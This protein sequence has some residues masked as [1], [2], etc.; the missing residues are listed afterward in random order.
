MM[1][2]GLTVV[3]I[4]V[5]ALTLARGQTPPPGYQGSCTDAGCHAEYAKRPV[6]HSPVET[7][8]CDA[9]HEVADE[10]AHKFEFTAEESELCVECHE[11]D[12]VK[13]VH[14]PV[15]DGTCT[16]CHDPH[17]SQN[18]KLLTADSEAALCFECHDDFSDEHEFLHGPVA[19][20][21]CTAC[22]L[23]HGSDHG[24]IL[25]AEGSGLCLRCHSDMGSRI[26]KDAGVHEPVKGGCVDC[27]DPH[28]ADHR[29]FV[30]SAQ[31]DLCLDCH[32]EISDLVDDAEVGHDA[33]T[34]DRACLN[35]HDPHE[36]AHG[37][38]LLNKP[39][40]LCLKCHNQEL[41]SGD[42][43]LANIAKHLKEKPHH[44]GPIQDEDCT[45]CHT[46]HGGEFFRLL[47]G[48]FPGSFY[49][50]YSEDGYALCFECHDVELA[51]EEATDEATGFRN[52]EKNLHFVHVNREV[53]GRTCR[54]CH[55]FH[56]SD[57]DKHIA[58]TVPFGEWAIPINYRATEAG[59]S[60]QP[61][62][63]KRYTYDR[64]TAV[65]N[66]PAP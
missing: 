65:V 21:T 41:P 43:K 12:D 27:H 46:P 23:P 40:A 52:G 2:R 57:N 35:C 4:A 7:G 20:E 55:D 1:L 64:E 25:V 3:V 13:T 47:T 19:A 11:F 6:I 58:R 66:L 8:T 22:H 44:H 39:M 17:A 24:S 59:G 53:K 61:G 33:V 32:D 56:A 38:L 9:C 18:A 50:S 48:A 14:Q 63:H 49:S 16:A 34:V 36:S 51:E 10:K 45:A 60:C 30:T 62:C 31:P 28:G 54:A 26:K 37:S 5:T 42:R 29:L 15:E